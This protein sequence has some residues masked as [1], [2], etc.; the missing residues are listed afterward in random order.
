MSAKS[1]NAKSPAGQNSIT[2]AFW[3]VPAETAMGDLGSSEKGLTGP[4]IQRRLDKYG[5]NVLGKRRGS[6]A[7]VLLLRQFS[8]PIVLMLIAAALLSLLLHDPTDA[9]IILAIVFISGLLGFW[10]ERGAANTV[11]KLLETVELK[12]TLVRDGAEAQVPVDEVVP[13]DVVLLSAGSGIPADCLLLSARDLFVDEAALT[14]ETY[15][16]E[17]QPGLFSPDTPMALRTNA[18]FLGTH[19]VSGSGEALVV[20]TGRATQF[21][22]ISERL[23][24]RPD[25]EFE[26][27]VRRFGY[28]LLEVTLV[29]LIVIFAVNAYLEKHILNSF[30]FA[31]AL[32]VG[33]TP[34]LLPA[35]ISV[36]LAKGATEMARKKV[37]VKRLSSIENFGSMSVLCSDKTGTL[38]EGKVKVQKAVDPAGRESDQVLFYAYLNATFQTG[39][40]NPID[41]AIRESRQVDTGA[42][43]RIDEVPYD[44]VR[45]RLSVL[46]TDG[47]D[48]RLIT[49]GA[50]DNVM[51]ICTA[52]VNGDGATV[53]MAEAAQA[54]LKL[55]EQI[56]SEGFRTL[57]IAIRDMPLDAAHIARGDEKD[58]TFAGL[59]VLHDPPKPGIGETIRT[60]RH[61]GVLLKVI[62]GDNH[63]VAAQLARSIGFAEPKLMTGG[64]LLHL[65][66]SALSIRAN[67]TDVF[68][69]IEPNQKERIILSLRK[70]GHVVGYIGDGINDA[71]ALH[72][73]DVSVSVQSAVDVAKEAADIVL[74][75]RDLAV[76]LDGVREGRRTFAN[77]LKYVFMATSANFGN[78]FSMALA[79]LILP[80]LPLLPKQILLTNLLT[81]FPELTIATDNVD[82]EW[83]DRPQRWNV[84]FIRGFMLVFGTVSS[85][86]DFLT[87]AILL[88]VLRAGV[89]EFRTGWFVESVVSSAF[90]VLVVRTRRNPLSSRPSG[91]LL[92]ATLLVAAAA[93]VLPFTPLGGLFG[94]VAIPPV[95]V[96]LMAGVVILYMATAAIAVRWFYRSTGFRDRRGDKEWIRASR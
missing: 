83:V 88:L 13:G 60:L 29:L 73:A 96:V 34:Q 17:K 46:C 49:K 8:N 16:V 44:F 9:A 42:W 71:P 92:T 77:T 31:L 79:S 39:F 87:F 89:N 64:E 51:Q 2:E 48:T 52:A 19:V 78:M 41:T 7:G 94:F 74:L 3:S 40:S 95:F 37:I 45:K 75:E 12:T 81:D 70:A 18:L 80:F 58:L 90:V 20:R 6:A 85:L 14:G 93:I 61:M 21:G 72:A 63:I 82:R 24:A 56:S 57:G 47:Q 27:G 66:D 76:L 23:R 54:I 28:F 69:E 10:Q 32:A 4:E 50:V 11:E 33:L 43:R 5:H 65:N 36:N 68:A 86:F 84:A 30:L 53:P 25:T 38:T 55:H 91:P 26:H 67:E 1:K 35:I 59:L 15:P 22:A 62:T